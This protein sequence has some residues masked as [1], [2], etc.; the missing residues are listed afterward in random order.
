MNVPASQSYP[1]ATDTSAKTVPPPERAQA[2]WNFWTFVSFFV[3]QRAA[4]VFKL[5]SVIVPAFLDSLGGGATARGFL[6]I[7]ARVGNS[8]PPFFI[9]PS[10]ERL[11]RMKNYLACLTLMEGAPWLILG[12]LLWWMRPVNAWVWQIGYLTLYAIFAAVNGVTTLTHGALQGKLIPPPRRGA[13]FA[14]SNFGGSLLGV[15]LVFVWMLPYLDL[16]AGPSGFTSV[17][18]ATGFLFLLNA[19]S[20]GCF[21][22][23]AS[24]VTPHADSLLVFLKQSIVSLRTDRAFRRLMIVVSMFY[25]FLVLFPHYASHG[26]KQVGA[27]S[28]DLAVWVVVQNI[29]LGVG[30]ML[31]GPIA[32]RRGYRIAFTMILIGLAIIPLL[33]IGIGLLGPAWG[34]PL[35][36]IVFLCL[37]LAPASQRILANYVLEF[38]PADQQARYLGIVNVTQLV[39]LTASPLVG[40]MMETFSYEAAFLLGSFILFWAAWRS[41][42]LEEPR[43][44][45]PSIAS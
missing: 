20:A 34:R 26:R 38:A 8:L 12:I 19:A 25:F 10:I 45:I 42:K 13:L 6:P 29:G 39:P 30:S 23:P 32:D 44:R 36:S 21:R 1:A 35:Y 17:F 9:A 11:P 2:N 7:L 5:E 14:Y 3:L 37:G 4:W 27:L 15:S 18:L 40:W 33:A 28:A 24:K 22:E 31:L 16:A 41:R 43:H